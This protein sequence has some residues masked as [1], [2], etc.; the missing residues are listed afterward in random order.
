MT[1]NREN[2]SHPTPNKRSVGRPR[3][4]DEQKKLRLQSRLRDRSNLLYIELSKDYKDRWEA[5]KK[6][7]NVKNNNQLTQWLIERGEQSLARGG[8]L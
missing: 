4:S 1:E 8:K 2:Q 5:L 7:T 3:V 6:A